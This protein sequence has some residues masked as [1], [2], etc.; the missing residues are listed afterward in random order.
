MIKVIPREKELTF[1]PLANIDPEKLAEYIGEIFPDGI[2]PLS[3]E[4]MLGYSNH[5]GRIIRNKK[6]FTSRKFTSKR[7]RR[8]VLGNT[9][10]FAGKEI[11]MTKKLL[12]TYL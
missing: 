7:K 4:T 3:K 6:S 11:K 1:N 5:L 8:K 12:N 2:K 9:Y 10:I